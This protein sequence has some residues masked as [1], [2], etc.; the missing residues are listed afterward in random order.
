MSKMTSGGEGRGRGGAAS[1]GV[2]NEGCYTSSTT[3]NKSGSGVLVV[4]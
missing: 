2:R 3:R 1:P 4:V